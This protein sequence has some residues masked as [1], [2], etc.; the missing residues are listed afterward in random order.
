MYT[1]NAANSYKIFQILKE[2]PSP[3]TN[4]FFSDQNIQSIQ[5]T[6]QSKIYQLMNIQIPNQNISTLLAFL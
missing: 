5:N 2:T 6:I 4:Y 1:L 3:L